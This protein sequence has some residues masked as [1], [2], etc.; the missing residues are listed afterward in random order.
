MHE[1]IGKIAMVIVILAVC[2]GAAVAAGNYAENQRPP[3]IADP[4]PGQEVSV[5][6]GVISMVPAYTNNE[7][8][9]VG[10]NNQMIEEISLSELDGR[11]PYNNNHYGMYYR[12]TV[13]NNQFV[14]LVTAFSV[15][16]QK[17]GKKLKA[18]YLWMNMSMPAGVNVTE[19]FVNTGS[20]VI[21]S[22]T[23]KMVGDG[24]LKAYKIDMG[25]Y[26]KIP[27]GIQVMQTIQNDK[28]T[29]RSVET[30]GA[31]AKLEW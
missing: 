3:E 10:S 14:Y 4:S 30:Y 13:R 24:T 27:G 21:Y 7:T 20:T 28:S 6:P 31:G 11:D 5:S 8:F 29:N 16:S 17:D 22:S 25:S 9:W 23:T 19:T 15:P 18:R 2:T 12:F 26:Q 1:T